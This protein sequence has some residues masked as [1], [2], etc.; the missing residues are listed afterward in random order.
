DDKFAIQHQVDIYQPPE[1][2]I[3]TD[4]M[5]PITNRQMNNA[6]ASNY[7]APYPYQQHY[8]SSQHSAY[9]YM[10]KQQQYQQSTSANVGANASMSEHS[11]ASTPTPTLTSTLS[12]V[13][14]S[15]TPSLS[16]C[17][18]TLPN[19]NGVGS[20][21]H[22]H[23]NNASCHGNDH[24]SLSPTAMTSPSSHTFQSPASPEQMAAL[25]SPLNTNDGSHTVGHAMSNWTATHNGSS[26]EQEISAQS[27][28]AVTS[29]AA[30][31]V[32]RDYMASIH[33]GNGNSHGMDGSSTTP[34]PKVDRSSPV[35]AY[36]SNTPQQPAHLYSPQ[37]S[38]QS[39]PQPQANNWVASMTST[40]ELQNGI[41]DDHARPSHSRT[42]SQPVKPATVSHAYGT[43]G[44]QNLSAIG[45]LPLLSPSH[46]IHQEMDMHEPP[47]IMSHLDY[48]V[49]TSAVTSSLAATAYNGNNNGA[50]F[51]PIR[52][53]P[54]KS[55]TDS[56][57]SLREFEGMNRTRAS[58]VNST[59]SSSTGSNG[60]L[61][62]LTSIS[63][64]GGADFVGTTVSST[65]PK[66]GDEYDYHHGQYQSTSP[67]MQQRIRTEDEDEDD[68][69]PSMIAR[70]RK[71]AL[72]RK[73]FAA[74]VFEC[75]VPGCAKAYTQLHNLKSH[76]RTGHTPVIKLKP[77]HCII[78]G[79]TKAFSQRKSLA[80]HIKNSHEDFK[81]KPFKCVQPGCDKA[82]TQLHN[83]RTHEKTV[84]LLD[85]SRKRNGGNNAVGPHIA[86]PEKKASL[87][88]L[89][90][91]AGPMGFGTV[92]AVAAA[93]A[94]A[95]AVGMGPVPGHHAP[96]HHHLSHS[97][98]FSTSSHNNGGNGNSHSGYAMDHYHH[99]RSNSMP[100]HSSSS[101]PSSGHPGLGLSYDGYDSFDSF[102]NGSN[103]ASHGND[104][105]AVAAVAA[106]VAASVEDDFRRMHY[107]PHAQV[108]SVA[109]TTTAAAAAA[110]AHHGHHPYAR[111]QTATAAYQSPY[112]S[113]SYASPTY[114]AQYQQ[115]A[116]GVHMR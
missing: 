56:V 60:L 50:R 42:Q 24:R 38:Q 65:V 115:Q 83:L 80:I 51:G 25:T 44:Q 45:G 104:A 58:S 97:S 7:Q 27:P 110:V 100:Y 68:E 41:I 107:H 49:S 35:S 86:G 54:K 4:L 14:T 39:Q 11:N 71:S 105:G 18:S 43:Q 26:L 46:L 99:G 6:N 82:Y 98:S 89:T 94:A 29:Q 36:Y 20:M 73:A 63:L 112:A 64:N 92:Q 55:R 21:G 90:G 69:F 93:A 79:C 1:Q 70:P 52:T 66:T 67:S 59:T 12:T 19:T 23:S 2:G 114:S 10:T 113:Q 37:E 3:D 31:A 103:G 28:Q 75:S 116:M 17:A 111:M 74:R 108:N 88:S 78:E 8:G 13:S 106:S 77:F 30:A 96:H 76:E 47:T 9:N 34:S 84:H 5:T 91:M 16:S 40:G 61:N 53:N 62:S 85:L 87:G 15:S 72:P 102:N 57:G 95:A 48:R 22:S 33:N 101:S 32:A 109:A 81:F